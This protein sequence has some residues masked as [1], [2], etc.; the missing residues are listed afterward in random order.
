MANSF[1]RHQN[2]F[3]G[4]SEIM[5]DWVEAAQVIGT[6]GVAGVV[7]PGTRI[8]FIQTTDVDIRNPQPA[9]GQTASYHS[10]LLVLRG[11]KFNTT[12]EIIFSGNTQKIQ[13]FFPPS[14]LPP[15]P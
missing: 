12:L 11:V 4:L 7:Q 14:L 6:L 10:V 15:L 13:P 8:G 9:C 5:H 3:V 2:G 1:G